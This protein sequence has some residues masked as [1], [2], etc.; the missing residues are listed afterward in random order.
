MNSK[1]CEACK[2][3]TF[4]IIENA[5][6]PNQP[7]K[8][9]EEC[10]K[11]LGKYSL[12][13][14]EWY[15]LASIHGPAKFLLHDDFYDEN[16]TATL[17]EVEV[18]IRSGLVAPGLKEVARDLQELLSFAT[19][20]YFLN[21]EIFDALKRFD[22]AEILKLLRDRVSKLP[23]MHIEA[24]AYEICANVVNK[25]AEEWI[26]ER[27]KRESILLFPLAQASASCLPHEEGYNLVINHLKRLSEKEIPAASAALSWFRTES[28]LDWIEE[29]V[30]SPI[31]TYWGPLAALSNLTWARVE[32]WLDMGRPYNF[33]ALDALKACWNYNTGLLMRFTPH[34][35]QPDSIDKM[36]EKLLSHRQLDPVPRVRQNVDSIINNWGRICMHTSREY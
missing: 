32:K 27:W 18:I 11:R 4:E 20:K 3:K 22:K 15:N 28:V 35:L 2:Q 1:L 17:Q 24:Q 31:S 26:R 7:Y 29:R 34:L 30:S 10:H 9:C 8:L 21:N 25:E 14:I 5:D 13:P 12:R 23:N 36:T 19:T 16:G 6:D 33:L